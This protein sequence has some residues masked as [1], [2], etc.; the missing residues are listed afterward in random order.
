MQI[1]RYSALCRFHPGGEGC[2]IKHF[3][4][5]VRSCPEHCWLEELPDDQRKKMGVERDPESA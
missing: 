3:A 2:V 5:A 4:E 1:R